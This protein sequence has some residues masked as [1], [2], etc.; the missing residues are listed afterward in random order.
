[1]SRTKR[2]SK[3][4]GYEYWSARPFNKAG[5]CISPNGGK[6]TKKRTHKAE[7]Q[8]NKPKRKDFEQ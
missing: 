3:G 6:H 7:R 2:G 4:P 1:M 5:G 8:M